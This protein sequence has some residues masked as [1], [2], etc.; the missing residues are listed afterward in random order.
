[1]SAAASA[2]EVV[3]LRAGTPGKMACGAGAD[4]WRSLNADEHT[5]LDRVTSPDGGTGCATTQRVRWRFSIPPGSPQTVLTLRV[6]YQ[7]GMVAYLDGLE[8]ARRR[9]AP[10]TAIDGVSTDVHGLEWERIAISPSAL[11][12]G[13]THVLAV[14]VH[15]HTLGRE[16]SVDV[17]LS[18]AD[19]PRI[20]HGPYLLDVTTR[21][22][23]IGLETDVPSTV[24]LVYGTGETLG[25][26]ATEEKVGLARHHVLVLSGLRAA[27]AY[28]YQVTARAPAIQTVATTNVLSM[29]TPPTSGRPL[30]F[31]IYGDVRSG[32][33]IHAEIARAIL[34]E[35]PDLAIST[36]DLVDMGS[37][38]AEWDRY[39]EVANP[40]IGS[41]LVRVAIGNHEYA[42]GGKGVEL[43]RSL[44]GPDDPRTPMWGSFD[45]AGVHFVYLDST[46]YGAPVQLAWLKRDLDKT[47]GAR[48]IIVYAH[49]GAY[50]SGL[51]GDNETAKAQYVPVLE[52][53]GVTLFVGGHDHHYERGKVGTLEYMVSGGGGAELRTQR[54]GVP[55]KKPCLPRVAHFA[56]EHHYVLV[57]VLP[58]L[59]RI[60]P[61]RADGSPLEPCFTR[62]LPR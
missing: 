1:M 11:S 34:A 23:R 19:G 3:W 28:H 56:N 60:C 52:Q 14:E 43:Y 49:H 61:K 45:V 44:F 59:L 54:C 13:D 57:E 30:R 27:T 35:D 20:V 46:R 51:H 17:E 50:T 62:P 33:D 42:R 47:K 36:G 53:H 31:A 32:H 48:A 58:K 41:V 15:P 2:N 4:D 16:P 21:G 26:Q 6:R 18:A 12:A 22:A 10:G 25:A 7:H 9:V 5:F 29:H 55:G 38:E 37:D 24:T 39:F 8:V 40:L